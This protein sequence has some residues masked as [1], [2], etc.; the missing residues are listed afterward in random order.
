[1][2]Q[3]WQSSVIPIDVEIAA[4]N[5]PGA[6]GKGYSKVARRTGLWISAVP[7]AI[8]ATVKKASGMT[9]L[10]SR[11]SIRNMPPSINSSSE[12]WLSL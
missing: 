4:T 1:M 10:S 6:S 11:R 3:I 8:I 2:Q 9:F 7:T 12:P 5:L